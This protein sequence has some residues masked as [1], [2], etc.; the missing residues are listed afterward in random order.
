MNPGAVRGIVGML[1]AAALAAAPHA[2]SQTPEEL[3]KATFTY[4]F[5]SFVTWPQA[6]FPEESAPVRL[7]VLGA[8]P[9]AQVLDKATQAQRVGGRPLAVRRLTGA[10]EAVQCN[11]VYVTGERAEAT[12]RATR[13]RPVLTVTD[14][15]HG[16]GELRGIVHF[17]IVDSHVRF[18]IDDAKAAESRLLIDPRLLSLAL[19]VRRRPTS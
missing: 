18:H 9:F 10:E 16:R 7:C 15:V 6:S 13:G 17:V 1:V 19:S 2:A 14:S 5:A 12:L 3:V 11:I 4:R 8:E